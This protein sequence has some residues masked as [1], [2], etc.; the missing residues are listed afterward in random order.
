M[1]SVIAD[2]L[3]DEH[4]DVFDL[5]YDETNSSCIVIGDLN[6]RGKYKQTGRNGEHTGGEN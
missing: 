3:G 5:I 6:I 4:W 2:I 1:M